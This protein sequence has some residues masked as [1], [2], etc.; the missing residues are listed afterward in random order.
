MILPA[1][2]PHSAARDFLR[3]RRLGRGSRARGSRRAIWPVSRA[4]SPA[5]L[6]ALP[7]QWSYATPRTV[8]GRRLPA[9]PLVPDCRSRLRRSEHVPV[10]QI[11]IYRARRPSVFAINV[12]FALRPS[13][14]QR[15]LVHFRSAAAERARFKLNGIIG[16]HAFSLV[17]RPNNSFK[18]TAL[19]G[20]TRVCVPPQRSGLI[21]VLDQWLKSTGPCT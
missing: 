16:G 15:Q 6:P 2:F 3:G 14:R 1:S 10:L 9:R 8:A 18:P 4:K 20:L 5:S 13:F 19:R 12:K 17:A 7:L 11:E 21:Q